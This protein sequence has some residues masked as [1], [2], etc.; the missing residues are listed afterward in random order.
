MGIIFE[1]LENSHIKT[2]LINDNFDNLSTTTCLR[3]TNHSTTNAKMCFYQ[4]A[5]TFRITYNLIS[6]VSKYIWLSTKSLFRCFALVS[7]SANVGYCFFVYAQTF[8]T[9]CASKACTAIVPGDWATLLKC[10]FVIHNAHT[11]RSATD[12]HVPSKN[13]RNVFVLCSLSF[14]IGKIVDLRRFAAFTANIAKHLA[15]RVAHTHMM[16]GANVNI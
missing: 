1:P 13:T 16:Y 5:H 9:H 10:A 11:R 12:S 4:L 15:L 8:T 6:I 3:S 14:R 2:S 7:Y